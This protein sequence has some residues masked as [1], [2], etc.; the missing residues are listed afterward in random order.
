MTTSVNKRQDVHDGVDKEKG[1]VHNGSNS[2]VMASNDKYQRL[3][4]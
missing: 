2:T 3:F 1:I 4:T